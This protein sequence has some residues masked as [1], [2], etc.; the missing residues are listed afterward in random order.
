MRKEFLHF[1]AEQNLFPFDRTERF[2]KTLQYA[3][4]PIGAI[5]FRYGLIT[6]AD[7]DDILDEQ[8]RAYRPF[9]EIAVDKHLLT[10]QQ[11]EVLLYIQQMRGAIEAAEALA[12]AEVCPVDRLVT[13][14]GRFL[15]N[16]QGVPADSR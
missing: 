12:L 5:A 11:L 16:L 7:I 4:E 14:L 6:G 3:P 9:G 2:Y 15:S 1:L 13:H 10:E 8:R